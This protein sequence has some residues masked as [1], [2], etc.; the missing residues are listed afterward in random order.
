MV[1]A[2]LLAP[3][4]S[5][6]PAFPNG[7]PSRGERAQ[8]HAVE[9][10]RRLQRRDRAGVA[11]DF[12]IPAPLRGRVRAAGESLLFLRPVGGGYAGGDVDVSGVEPNL[13]SS[14]A[15]DHPQ[16]PRGLPQ[17]AAT[18]NDTDSGPTV[19]MSP[20]ATTRTDTSL[21]AR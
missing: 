1:R 5:I 7:P 12:P 6:S 11:P 17:R 19:V 8:W 16:S 4:S 2:G 13:A 18:T 20:T 3:G 15:K 21:P 14:S 10:T 9:R